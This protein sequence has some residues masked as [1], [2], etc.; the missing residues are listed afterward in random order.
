MPLSK[1]ETLL[2]E[3][4]KYAVRF[5]QRQ[6]SLLTMTETTQKYIV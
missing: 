5:V 1:Y 6:D 4:S 2:A 3:S